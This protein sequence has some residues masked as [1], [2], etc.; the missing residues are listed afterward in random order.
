[1]PERNDIRTP[2]NQ[3]F[4]FQGILELYKVKAT[5]RR[6]HGSDMDAAC[7]TLRNRHLNIEPENIW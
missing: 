6:E 1:M 7:D 2:R 5:I 4:K 3:I